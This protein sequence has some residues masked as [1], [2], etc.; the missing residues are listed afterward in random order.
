M[1]FFAAIICQWQGDLSTGFKTGKIFVNEVCI[2]LAQILK[3]WSAEDDQSVK[4]QWNLYQDFSKRDGMG[5]PDAGDPV[6]ASHG[7]LL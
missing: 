1:F 2:F 5:Q 4:G 3:T 6:S 7:H